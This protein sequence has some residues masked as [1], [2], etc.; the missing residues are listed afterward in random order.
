MNGISVLIKRTA[1]SS[2]PL[3]PHGGTVR[4]WPSMSEEAGSHQT[5]NLILYFPA[6]KTVRNKCLLCKPPRL[7]CSVI[8]A[9]RDQAF[10][11][12]ILG[13]ALPPIVTSSSQPCSPQ[14]H[15]SPRPSRPGCC[16]P[17]AP[18]LSLPS[19]EFLV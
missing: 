13:R 19:L 4:R 1:E 7:W 16:P 15:T 14:I 12:W 10:S 18:S 2:L 3:L 9:Q 6:S 5:L 8:A 17:L 11:I